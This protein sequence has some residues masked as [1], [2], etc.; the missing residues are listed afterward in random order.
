VEIDRLPASVATLYAELLEL[1]LLH[2]RVVGIEGLLPG[3]I[4]GKS[5]RGRRYLYWQV[6]K[7]DQVVQRYLGPDSKELRRTLDAIANKR[8]E[9]AEQR[10]TMDRLAAMLLKGGAQREQAGVTAVLSLLADLGLFRRGAV[11]VGTQAFRAYGGLLGVRLPG[12]SL[13]T[14]DIDGAHRI[15][16]AVAAAPEG[17]PEVEGSR[18]RLGFLAVPGLDPREPSTSFKVR[19]GELRLDFVTPSRR[20]A[21]EA[22]VTVPG[23]GVSA[24]P[25]RFLDYLIEEPVPALVLAARPILVRVPRPGRFALH[26]LLTSAQRPAAAQ[27]KAGKDRAQAAALIAVLA[28]DRPDDLYEALT[29]LDTRPSAHRRVLKELNRMSPDYRGWLGRS[30]GR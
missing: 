23:L 17:A 8:V 2:E 24:W 14:Q 12:A 1:A 9:S 26:K 27:T 25:L 7:G 6:R 15:D 3:G 10:A 20:K 5:I 16:V 28:D 11:L 21:A 30:A 4:V 19:R 18:A 13:R 29:A 22:P